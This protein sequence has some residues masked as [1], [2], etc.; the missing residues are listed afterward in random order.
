M[1]PSVEEPAECGGGG[2]KQDV[3]DLKTARAFP[4]FG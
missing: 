3:F 4:R 1:L 2:E